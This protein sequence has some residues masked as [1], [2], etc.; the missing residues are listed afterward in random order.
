MLTEAG[1]QAIMAAQSSRDARLAI[2][3]D[4]IDNDGDLGGL[5]QQVEALH[6]KYV[7]LGAP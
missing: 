7:C 1:A 6:G 5:A 2:A 3:D 4:V